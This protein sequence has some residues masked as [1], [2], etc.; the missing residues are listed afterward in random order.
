MN[1]VIGLL[2]LLSRTEL[3]GQQEKY[4]NLA[5][6][7]A[8]RMMDIVGDVLDFSKI[9]AGHLS[10]DPAPFNLQE[11]LDEI[12]RTLTVSAQEKGVE[13]FYR[14]QPGVTAEVIG[15]AGRLRQILSNLIGNAIKFTNQGEVMVEVG[16]KAE[17]DNEK[18]T[19]LF[20]VHD[21]GIGITANN[22]KNIFNAF[23][24]GDGSATRKY[25][26]TGLGLAIASELIQLMDGHIGVESEPGKGRLLSLYRH[27]QKTEHNH[28]HQ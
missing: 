25:G 13:L 11:L 23:A 22:Q 12:L 26:G 17:A 21:T 20:A 1:G 9:E 10:L 18:V 2:E 8:H 5:K 16:N 4:I 28:G 27:P 14:I 19:L 3:D 6:T 15:D 24:Q 7:S